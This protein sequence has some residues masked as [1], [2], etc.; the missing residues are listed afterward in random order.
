MLYQFWIAYLT[1]A[2]REVLRFTRIWVQTIIP[3]VMMVAL[4]FIIF[5][6]LI[7]QLEA[8]GIVVERMRN[9][10]NRLEELFV[11]MTSKA[12]KMGLG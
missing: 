2:R 1:I 5:G 4:Y 6:N 7:G 12:D 9:K 10:V 8:Q 11:K 3:P